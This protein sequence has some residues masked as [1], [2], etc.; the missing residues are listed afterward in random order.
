MD[1]LKGSVTLYDGAGNAVVKDLPAAAL[2]SAD[3]RTMRDFKKILQRYQL[4]HNFRCAKCGQ[5][6]NGQPGYLDW[7]IEPGKI[8]LMCGCR[9]IVFLGQTL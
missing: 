4:Q 1:T 3:A 5:N 8:I 7:T 9:Q 6:R 2:S